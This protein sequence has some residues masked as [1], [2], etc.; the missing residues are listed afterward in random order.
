MGSVTDSGSSSTVSVSTVSATAAAELLESLSLPAADSC[1]V[2]VELDALLLLSEEAF[3]S[4][5][6]DWLLVFSVLEFEL[7]DWFLV[8]DWAVALFPG[9]EFASLL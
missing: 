5:P 1:S 7:D 4:V 9:F 8:D 3:E 2:F 6:V